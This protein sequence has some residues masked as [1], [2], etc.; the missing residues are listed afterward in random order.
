MRGVASFVACALALFVFVAPASARDLVIFAAASLKNA[1]DPATE[2]YRAAGG[3][4]CDISYAASSTLARQIANGAP[5]DVFISADRDWMDYL[6]Q[7]DLMEDGTR[8]DLLGNRLVMIAPAASTVTVDIEPGFS[9][10]TL[11][12]DGRLAI[13]DPAG[14]PAGKYGKAALEKLG[15]WSSIAGKIAPAEDVR[16][17]LTFVS[18]GEAPLGIVYATDAAVDAGVKIVGAFPPDSYPRIV[19]PMAAMRA[20]KDGGAAGLLKFLQSA[21]ARRIFERWGFTF[22]AAGKS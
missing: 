18:R 11:L 7:R 2:A 16:A 19:Y 22:L 3:E 13:A 14:V 10:S 12:G 4:K 15:V 8:V 1:L 5:A 17:A 21:M 20:G 6:Q 9:L